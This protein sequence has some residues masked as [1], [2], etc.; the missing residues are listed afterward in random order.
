MEKE[1]NLVKKVAEKVKE[2]GGV[3]YFV[4]GFVRDH[5]LG[6]E[7]KDIDVEIHGIT[8]STLVEILNTFGHVDLVGES[9]GVYLIKGVDIDFAMPRQERKVGDKH[10]DF[11]VTVDPFIG[12]YEASKRRD[13]TMNAIMKDVLTGDVTDHFGGVQDIQHRVIKLVDKKTFQEDALR[14][15]RAI[16]FSARFGFEIEEE[17]KSVMKEMDLTFLAKERVYMEIEKGMTKGYPSVFVSQLK[18]FDTV[19]I[20]LPTLKKASLGFMDKKNDLSMNTALMGI[21]M[22]DVEFDAFV[23]EFIQDKQ[24]RKKAILTRSL[25]VESQHADS[26]HSMALTIA[27]YRNFIDGNCPAVTRMMTSVLNKE[28]L[29]L[30]KRVLAYKEQVH[31][32][33]DGNWLQEIGVKPSPQF[34]LLLD[35]ANALSFMGFSEEQIKNRI[36]FINL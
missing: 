5:L 9:F 24:G 17:T 12:T 22:Y 1:M 13:F 16:Q 31:F 19:S 20:I 26:A 32:V 2:A 25:L 29:S 27:R 4:G 11:D 18:R 34:K 30:F 7:S 21:E 8:E 36:F 23:K 28:Q 3:M 14:V 6:K 35:E 15:L 10:T 33:I